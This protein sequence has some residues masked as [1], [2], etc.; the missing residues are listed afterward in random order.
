LRMSGICK[1]PFGTPLNK[2]HP[3]AQGLVAS[4][5]FNENSG[6]TVYDSSGNE[7]RGTMFGFG[8]G[9]TPTSGWVPG[10]HG[11]ALAFPVP[12][13][14]IPIMALR[15]YKIGA[16]VV[17]IA[18]RGAFSGN[19]GTQKHILSGGVKEFYFSASSSK[20]VY[21][22]PNGTSLILSDS[23]VWDSRSYCVAVVSDGQTLSMYVDAL[24]QSSTIA[25]G[26]NNLFGASDI[27]IWRSTTGLNGNI[28]LLQFYSRALSPEEIAY[29]S[30]FPYCMYDNVLEYPYDFVPTKHLYGDISSSSILQD[31]PLKRRIPILPGTVGSTA[32]ILGNSYLNRRLL[33]SYIRSST[34]ITGGDIRGY[35]EC[36]AYG[37]SVVSKT[38]SRKSKVTITTEENSGL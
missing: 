32:D 21:V 9:D 1:P 7:N 20:L 30:A 31:T 2:D 11:G 24:I 29:L 16:I 12:G 22:L 17:H 37:S 18:P 4:Y 23:G 10:P 36:I 27:I 5:L 19:T 35:P 14:S 3:L 13:A 28:S 34:D 8:A 33:A 6:R 15:N 38:A 26:A 25:M